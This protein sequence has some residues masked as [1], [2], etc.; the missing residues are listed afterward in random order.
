[1][2]IIQHTNT[3]IEFSDEVLAWVDADTNLMWEVKNKE[4]CD[5]MYV[6]H[7]N[8]VKNAPIQKGVNYE[9][10]VKDTTSYVERLNELQYASFSDWRLPTIDELES[11]IEH[12]ANSKY[13]TKNALIKN[14]M[15]EYWSSSPQSVI[16]V[17]TVP[18]TDWRD[19][20]HIPAIDIV[21]FT[22][23]EKGGYKPD[24]S[25]WVRCVRSNNN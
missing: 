21:N 9:K 3:T 11:L 24:N 18:G 8:N 16:N 13:F 23:P 20:A 17:M 14:T 25:L 5:F 12:E 10:E 7:T 15:P 4:N 2:T 1:M 22:I 19:T 6:W